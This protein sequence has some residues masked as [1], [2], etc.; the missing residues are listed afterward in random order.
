[1]PLKNI[2]DFLSVAQQLKTDVRIF[3]KVY[4]LQWFDD[5][6]QKQG[7]TD[8]AFTA[9]P[10]RKN[11]KD[12]GRAVLIDTTFL[13]KSLQV[14]SEDNRRITFGTY[15]PYAGS[16]NNSERMRAVQYVTAHTRNRNGR[17][18]QVQAHTRRINTQYTERKF[19]GESQKMMQ[20]LDNWLHTE[21]I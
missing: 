6:F 11:D 16:Q 8:A 17:R 7:F 14:L 5:S 20:G 13:R 15:V 9:W 10:K 2:P 19:I 12:P 21:I 4:C 3:A 1:M 18:E